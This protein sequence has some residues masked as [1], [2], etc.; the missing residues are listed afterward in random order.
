MKAIETT[1]NAYWRGEN[2]TA[3]HFPTLAQAQLPNATP[4]H[5]SLRKNPNTTQ[6]ASPRRAKRMVSPCKRYGFTLQKV[7][8]R[9]A[10]RMLLPA[11]ASALAS[12]KTK[13][14]P[15]KKTRATFP[16]F[17]NG[18]KAAHTCSAPAR[19]AKPSISPF[20]MSMTSLC[21]CLGSPG[22]RMMSPAMATIM[23]EPVL[24]TKSRTVKV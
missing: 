18:R 10:K 4:P 13:R 23:P 2:R 3:K 8:F 6:G 19:Y 5:A 1:R 11:R 24:M 17:A 9:R 14:R 22:M 12:R 15:V 7:C 21:G 20:T 16:P